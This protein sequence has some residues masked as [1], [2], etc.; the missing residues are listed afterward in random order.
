MP[1]FSA[2]S[3]TQVC[4]K[5]FRAAGVPD[6]ES[7]VVTR[8]MVDANLTGHH[9]HG[10]IHLPKYIQEIEAAL[11]EPGAKIECKRE[12]PS[13]AVLNGNWGFGAVIATHS[14]ELA[15]Q[16]AKDEDVSS[17]AAFRCNEVGRLGGYAMTAAE[18]GMICIM[19]VNDHG[20]G[21]CVA[22]F[23]GIE[24]RLSTNPIACAI[25][26]AGC[27]PILLDMSTSVAASGKIGLQKNRQDMV[28]EGW[29]ID[30]EGNPTINV[31]DF[32]AVPP[33]A[34]LPFG[35][36]AAHKGFGLS[37]FID[38]LSG[39]LTGAG[40]SRGD[41]ARVGN[42]LFVIAINIASFVDVG[43]FNDEVKRFIAY[44]KSA[45]KSP[46]VEEIFIPG[47]RGFRE[48]NRQFQD[49][50]FIDDHTWEAIQAVAT[51]YRIRMTSVSS[52]E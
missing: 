2:E 24:G 36:I 12:S 45:K 39:A 52:G 13:M 17:V 48:K 38:I 8:S 23:G 42:G 19:T 22:P 43:E 26:V 14:V 20:G 21:P 15:V 6:A 9:S 31:E 27:E 10:V 5:V 40:C 32:Y 28:P 41:A 11:I 4:L 34:L 16:K 1:T 35:G 18:Q 50:I 46:G 29:L 33:G 3:L 37:F 44:I 25:P 30:S 49:G 7:D 51:K 47:E